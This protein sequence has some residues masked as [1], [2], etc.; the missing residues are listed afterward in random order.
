MRLCLL[1]HPSYVKEVLVNR[2]KEFIKGGAFYL[3]QSLLGEGLLTSEGE[4]HLRQRRLA[5]P[6]GEKPSGQSC[7][8]DED[9]VGRDAHGGPARSGPR[10]GS[11]NPPAG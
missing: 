4:S 10:G 3:A 2:E 1:N 11:G 5:Q 9:E 7:D 8:H 6:V